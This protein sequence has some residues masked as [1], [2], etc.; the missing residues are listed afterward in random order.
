MKVHRQFCTIS[1]NHTHNWIYIG[2][3]GFLLLSEYFQVCY[4]ILWIRTAAHFECWSVFTV[5]K[6]PQYTKGKFRISSVYQFSLLLKQ[7]KNININD[8]VLISTYY[9]RYL[10]HLGVKTRLSLV[11]NGAHITVIIFAGFRSVTLITRPFGA[12]LIICRE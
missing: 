8:R 2:M 10:R 9:P 11:D 3:H 12:G 4:K 5:A 7:K 1:N 6:S